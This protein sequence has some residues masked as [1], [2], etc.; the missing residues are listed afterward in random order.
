MT[1]LERRPVTSGAAQ[2]TAEQDVET[3]V[4]HP[5]DM[6]DR[7]DRRPC[8]LCRSRTRPVVPVGCAYGWDLC[9]R[10]FAGYRHVQRYST[11]AAVNAWTERVAELL[12]DAERRAA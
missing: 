6:S 4:P 8:R 10:C 1:T 9:A 11:P 7:T 3:S 2:E 5:A 12:A